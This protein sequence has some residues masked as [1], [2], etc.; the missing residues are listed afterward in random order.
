MVAQELQFQKEQIVA[1]LAELLPEE[2]IRDV[3]S[4]IGAVR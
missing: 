4:R 3:R 2:Q 1:R